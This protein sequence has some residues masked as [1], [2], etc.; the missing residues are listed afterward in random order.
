MENSS[1]KYSFELQL[2]WKTHNVCRN[3]LLQ[4]YRKLEYSIYCGTIPCLYFKTIYLIVCNIGNLYKNWVWI[5]NEF[6]NCEKVVV[7]EPFPS[8]KENHNSFHG[9]IMNV[10]FG[11]LKLMFTLKCC[12]CNREYFIAIH[13]SSFCLTKLWLKP[14]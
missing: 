4:I 12:S 3:L 10:C 6:P 5:R 7:V 9:V 13:S 8:L 11:W 2:K 1:T 14:L